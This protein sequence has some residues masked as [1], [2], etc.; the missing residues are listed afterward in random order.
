M[1]RSPGGVDRDNPGVGMRHI[2]DAERRQRLGIRHHLAKRAPTVEE[3]AGDLVGLHSSDPATVF[4][5]ARARVTGLTV[6]SLE[7]VLYEDRSLLRIHG[8]RRTMFVAPLEVAA[9]MNAACTRAY[10]PREMARFGSLVE[11]NDIASD[12]ERWLTNLMDET[13]VALDRLGISAAA[14]LTKEVPL[15]ATRLHYG[16]GTFGISTRV[17]FLLA[18]AGRVMRGRPR[19]SWIASQYRWAQTG[20]W[21]D[22]PLPLVDT[23][24][25]RAELVRRWLLAFGPG[26][27]VDIQWW[28]GWSKTLTRAVLEEVGAEELTL[29]GGTGFVHPA[30]PD[31]PAASEPWVA[32]LP[33]LD[34]TPMGWKEREWFGGTFPGPH[35]DRNGNIGPTIWV[36]GQIVGAW[37]AGDGGIVRIRL[38]QEVAGALGERV[39]LERLALEQWLDGTRVT[40]R[41]R[42]PIEREMVS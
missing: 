30:D 14:D 10:L 20:D 36:D 25:A 7:E 33:G 35:Y 22:S 12:G 4:L 15:L 2:G 24:E 9:V 40:P 1:R 39:E 13:E 29:D 16:G 19:G 23:D 6:S 34:P 3:V 26:T 8:M 21:L 11:K 17:L 5:S 28:T 27:L 37:A 32:F 31:T 41:F 38:D 42:T 18:C